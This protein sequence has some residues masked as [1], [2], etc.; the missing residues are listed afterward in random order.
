MNPNKAPGLDCLHPHVQL[1]KN[2]VSSLTCPLFVLYTQSL[3][4]GKI[5]EERKRAN[6]M[7]IFKK[8]SKTEAKT[9]DQ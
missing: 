9:T 1:L 4:N 2:C 7:P 6:M 3:Y 8:G 5:P